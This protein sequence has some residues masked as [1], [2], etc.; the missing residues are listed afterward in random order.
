MISR[1]IN[2]DWLEVY[3]LE[4]NE[5]F[6]LDAD[7]YIQHGFDVRQREYGTRVWGEMFTIMGTDGERLL[8][9]RRAPKSASGLAN[10][11]IL[12]PRACHIRLCNRTC[13]YSDAVD[14]L[15]IFL[16]SWKY[17]VVRI[18]RIDIALDF[19]RFDYGDDPTK[20][21][22]R[23]LEDKYSKI[24]QANI[25]AHGR[26]GWDGRSWNSISWGSQTSQISTKFYNKSLEL[27]QVSDKP[28]IRQAW[29]AAGLVD[30]WVHMTKTTRD[31]AI[32]TPTIWRVEFAIKS[33]TRNW[34][35]MENQNGK[36]VQKQ[37]VRN[38]LAMYDTKPKLLDMF[39]SLAEHYFHFKYRVYLDDKK[40][41]T[42]NALNVVTLDKNHSL[43][44]GNRKPEKKLQRKD[45][46]PDKLL[47]NTSGM[48]HFYKLEN[49]ASAKPQSKTIDQLLRLLIEYRELHP[50]PDVYKACTLLIDKLTTAKAHEMA[51]VKWPSDM[52]TMLRQVIAK[53]IKGSSATLG[54]DIATTKALLQ[55]HDDIFGEIDKQTKTK[56]L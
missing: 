21:L 51:T 22:K 7:F 26:D 39:F 29:Q 41:L 9:V 56:K 20:F 16:Y 34:F 47:F 3:C 6:P 40:A 45:R 38:T 48:S 44:Q 15:R 8:E 17:D 54:E 37:S 10:D 35:I 1:C 42:A 49:I 5:F 13:Y 50:M 55:V 32:Y 28:Y 25:A 11:G 2:I 33:G 4:S 27:Q 23:Y 12:D 46:C 43:A 24:N 31:G 18:S 53:R 19:E 14:K 30:D 52:V 36:K